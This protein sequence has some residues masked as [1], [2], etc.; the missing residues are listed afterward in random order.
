MTGWTSASGY[1]SQQQQQLH[2]VTL[3]PVDD[4][5]MLSLRCYPYLYTKDGRY[6][7]G[8]RRGRHLTRFP[9]YDIAATPYEPPFVDCSSLF[10]NHHHHRG[11]QS[12]RDDDVTQLQSNSSTPDF[13]KDM[14]SVR[15]Y[16][17][18]I[19]H[20]RQHQLNYSS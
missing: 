13:Q 10:V 14:W 2:G 20:R 4:P 8:G 19:D 3:S 12:T 1:R 16:Q 9:R 17:S 6:D 15:E 7:N 5:W 18:L 11:L